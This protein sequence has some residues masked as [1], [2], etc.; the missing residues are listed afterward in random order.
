MSKSLLFLFFCALP[1][2]ASAETVIGTAYL[3]GTS[4]PKIL[5]TEKHVLEYAET[6]SSASSVLTTP[7]SLDKEMPSA[8]VKSEKSEVPRISK[9][10]TEYMSANKKIGFRQQEF[11]DTHY[12]PNIVFKDEVHNETY[13]ITV[14][15]TLGVLRSFFNGTEKT[16]EFKIKSDQV[17]TSSL[18]KFIYD[19]LDRLMES[20]SVVKCLIPRSHR[21]VSLQIK[22]QKLEGNLVTFSIQPTSILLKLFSSKT[23]VTFDQKTKHWKQYIGFSNL[24]DT[25][26]KISEVKIDYQPQALQ[27]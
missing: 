23:Y 26:G 14:N 2:S 4:E 25:K 5:Y 19:N 11:F 7:P 24:K 6:K 21:F 22:K 20:P 1:F 13:S 18:A 15:G 16:Y 12:V 27:N 17:T 9:I 8:V 3:Y 10:S